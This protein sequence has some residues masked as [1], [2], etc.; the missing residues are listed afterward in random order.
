[1]TFSS[2]RIGRLNSLNLVLTQRVQWRP[3]VTERF[4]RAIE[5][6]GQRRDDKLDVRIGAACALEQIV[7]DS[8]ELHWPIMEVLTA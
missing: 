5:Q 3:Q 4:T 6:L 7:R 8:A 1:L 2:V